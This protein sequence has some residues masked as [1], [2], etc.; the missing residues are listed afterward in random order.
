MSAEKGKAMHEPKKLRIL[1]AEEN[2]VT[3]RVLSNMLLYCGHA[4]AHF[5]DS[6]EAVLETLQNGG[7][8]LALLNWSLVADQD[9][10]L[11]KELREQGAYARMPLMVMVPGMDDECIAQ[12]SQY[13][14]HTYIPKPIPAHLLPEKI[15]EAVMSAPHG[16]DA[17]REQMREPANY[18]G[19][20]AQEP[21]ETVASPEL[22]SGAAV[23]GPVNPVSAPEPPTAQPARTPQDVH[24]SVVTEKAPGTLPGMADPMQA[25][26]RRKEGLSTIQQAKVLYKQGREALLRRSYQ[27]ALECFSQAVKTHKAFPEACKG[28]GLACRG[29]GDLNK[30][31]RFCNQAA[32]LYVRCGKTEA[33]GKLYLELRKAGLKPLNPFKVLAEACKANGKLETATTLFEQGARLT[34]TD[35]MI[36]YNLF[37]LHRRLGHEDKVLATV[38]RL[39]EATR[40][41]TDPGLRRNLVWAEGVY[42]KMTGHDFG[43]VAQ[44]DGQTPVTRGNAPSILIVDDEP[45][46]RMLLERSL[47]S[48]EDDGVALLFAEDG[49]EGLEMITQRRPELVFLDVMMPKMNGFDVCRAVKHEL[50]LNDVYIIMLT[51]KGQEFDRKRGLEAGADV[52]MTK[53]FRPQ[54][55]ANLARAVLDL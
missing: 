48:L 47:E 3:Q 34:P 37:L 52:Y 26:P 45:H 41:M 29:L 30:A 12:A 20:Q 22:L 6:P 35:P 31:R 50:G 4:P 32:Q 49:A 51:A 54:E 25:V 36:A 14:V 38:S 17:P 18:A 13:G 21:A 19:L 40:Q 46:I 1:V 55:L 39:L 8:D 27:E 9:F 28:L 15:Q 7:V 33:A 5:A 11:L 2:P 23:A 16:G 53:P 42:R 24:A 43:Q 10:A 44:E